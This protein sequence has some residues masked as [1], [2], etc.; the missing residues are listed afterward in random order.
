[1][2]LAAID[3]KWLIHEDILTES[4]TNGDIGRR[5]LVFPAPLGFSLGL[6]RSTMGLGLWIGAGSEHGYISDTT[7]VPGINYRLSTMAL[8]FLSFQLRVR[9]L[10]D[11]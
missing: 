9:H 1:M 7:T 5:Y 11:R 4:G 10:Q 3:G 8:Q 2:L 6:V